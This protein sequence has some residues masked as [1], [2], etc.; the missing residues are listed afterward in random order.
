MR[1]I[2]SRAK[3]KDNGE[4]IEGYS[5]KAHWYLDEKEIYSI[6][7]IDL[8]FYPH[9][10]ISEWVEIDPVTLC[11]CMGI[12]DKNGKQVF[13]ND[14]VSYDF[15]GQTIYGVIKYGWDDNEEN[16]DLI[17]PTNRNFGFYIDWINDGNILRS[18]I[19]C[20]EDGFEV[21]GNSF[22]DLESFK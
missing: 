5:V 9:G 18:N 13:E 17:D 1:D 10:E 6:L 11:R 15:E 19:G 8:C 14:V 16:D 7:P 12:K 21:V 22:D 3:R 2:L 20:W 4:W